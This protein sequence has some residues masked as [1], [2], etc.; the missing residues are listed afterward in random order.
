MKILT[1]WFLF[2]GVASATSYAPLEFPAE[3]T[4]AQV[5]EKS[6]FAIADEETLLMYLHAH[7][8]AA[9]YRL[10]DVT[11]REQKAI[12]AEFSR[13][14]KLRPSSFPNRF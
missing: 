3:P 7:W 12:S 10:S 14:A 1:Y 8:E 13:L 5:L 6:G 11:E 2:C 4:P 9:G